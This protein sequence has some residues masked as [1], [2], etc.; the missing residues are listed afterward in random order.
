MNKLILTICSLSIFLSSCSRNR[1]E[2]S[3]TLSSKAHSISSF[4]KIDVSNAFEVFIRFSDTD[5]KLLIEANDNL[6]D[7][8]VVNQ[9]GTELEIRLKRNT[10]ISGKSRLRAYITTTDLSVIE[11]SGASAIYFENDFIATSLD[12]DLSGASSFNGNLFL[13]NLEIEGSGSSD[14]EIQGESKNLNFD[15]SGASSIEDYGFSI[16]E[17]IRAELSGASSSKLRVDGN[18]YID[19]S[20]ASTFY[21]KGNG[22][23]KSQDLSGSSSIKKK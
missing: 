17:Q 12:L 15:L 8:I 11:A 10:S 19:A 14:F 13:D 22:N 23:I 1:V 16:S 3:A 20:G 21:Y 7:Y 4:S 9:R 18:M 6:H 5:E 2:P